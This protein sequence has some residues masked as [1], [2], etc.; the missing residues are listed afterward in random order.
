MINNTKKKQTLMMYL[1]CTKKHISGKCGKVHNFLMI[2][3]SMKGSIKWKNGSGKLSSNPGG[4][5]LYFFFYTN[6]FWKDMI[7]SF[8]FLTM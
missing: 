5:C 6:T 4:G 8:L 2:E 1:I 7:S 3:I